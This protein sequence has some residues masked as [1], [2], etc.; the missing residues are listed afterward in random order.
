MIF[1]GGRVN[2]S[3]PVNVTCRVIGVPLPAI[4]WKLNGNDVSLTSDCVENSYN[5][6]L[7]FGSELGSGFGS[8]NCRINQTLNLLNDV[9]VSAVSDPQDVITLGMYELS[10]LVVEST[11]IIR[12]LKRSDNGSYTC[13]VT[14]MLPGAS[15]VTDSVPIVVLGKE[16]VHVK[17]SSKV[18]CMYNRAPII[19]RAV[20]KN[21]LKSFK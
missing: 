9:V 5:A 10:Q 21:N 14:N 3:S 1:G 13:N 18:N 8:P 16:F 20:H 19:P 7:N 11:L 15:I 4:V 17:V 12:S 2:I 6:L